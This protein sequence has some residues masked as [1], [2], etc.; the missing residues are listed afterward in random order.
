MF[1]GRVRFG[2]IVRK[3]MLSSTLGM[4][5]QKRTISFTSQTTKALLLNPLRSMLG[6]GGQKRTISFTNKLLLNPLRGMLRRLPQKR[7]ISFTN[8]P[9]DGVVLEEG[10]LMHRVHG[11]VR[12]YIDQG[13][14]LHLSKVLVLMSCFTDDWALLRSVLMVSSLMSFTFHFMFPFPRPVR[15]GWGLL[16]FMGHAYSLM[17]F[18]REN[19]DITA[20]FDPNE[21]DM[22]ETKFRT[23][24][25][26]Q[27]YKRLLHLALRRDVGPHEAI[28][29]PGDDKLDKTF[30][31]V[32]VLILEGEAEMH[33]DG[34]VVSRLHRGS[35]CNVPVMTKQMLMAKPLGGGNAEHADAEESRMT[36]SSPKLSIRSTKNCKVLIWDLSKLADH[37]LNV[38]YEAARRGF[39]EVFQEA[40]FDQI[41]DK[42][43]DALNESY[44]LL[45]KKVLRNHSTIAESEK[46]PLDEYRQKHD[47]GD[48]E[49]L[50][51]L[52]EFGWSKAEY[53]AGIKERAA[54]AHNALQKLSNA[55]GHGVLHPED[56][57]VT[58]LSKGAEEMRGKTTLQKYSGKLFTGNPSQQVQLFG[59]GSFAAVAAQQH[60]RKMN[61]MRQ[62][63]PA[64]MSRA[65]TIASFKEFSSKVAR[66]QSMKPRPPE[67]PES[68]NDHGS[69]HGEKPA[70]RRRSTTIAQPPAQKVRFNMSANEEATIPEQKEEVPIAAPKPKASAAKALF[71]LVD[72]E[73]EGRGRARSTY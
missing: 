17:H 27:A 67:A 7:P 18:L 51:S 38:E 73:P 30:Q 29:G 10:Q 15:M 54:R 32:M 64:A 50:R 6:R 62:Q 1:T 56:S 31:N 21:L 66:R 36:S 8:L 46:K 13:M 55:I 14:M 71:P 53:N 70:S 43:H 9:D 68:S 47:I 45:M 39:H 11:A 20:S 22:W 3:D 63:K 40:I 26:P 28:S 61:E 12:G 5:P 4:R 72:P 48:D 41:L 16:F 65:D 49:H 19:Q 44:R 42:N 25:A 24:I 59:G 23:H 33:V 35:L 34:N 37:L 2:E 57:S 60:H 52:Q 69:N 58:H